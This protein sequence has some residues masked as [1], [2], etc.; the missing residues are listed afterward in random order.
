MSGGPTIIQSHLKMSSSSARP[1]DTPSG[2]FLFSS[3]K[4]SRWEFSQFER[5]KERQ[6]DSGFLQNRP[7]GGGKAGGGAV[8]VARTEQLPL[9]QFRCVIIRH[10]LFA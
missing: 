2:G 5:T 9:E 7:R 10:F 8:E 3:A 6:A 1:T 4:S